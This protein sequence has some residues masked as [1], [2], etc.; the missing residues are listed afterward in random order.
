[1]IKITDEASLPDPGRPEVFFSGALH[2]D[3]RV[4]PQAMTVLAE[5]LADH[6]SRPDGNPW[7]KQLVKT[8]TVAI[9]RTTNSYGYDHNKR[10]ELRVNPN[11]DFT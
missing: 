5:T 3:E 4:G 8:R 11:R 7:I 10:A 2:G 9:M 1:V 6:A